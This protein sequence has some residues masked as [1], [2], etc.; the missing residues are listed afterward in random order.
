MDTR[1]EALRTLHLVAS[2]GSF[3]KAA[4]ALKLTKATISKR[5]NE[6][7]SELGVRLLQRSTRRLSL[8]EAGQMLI[9]R[10]ESSLREIDEAFSELEGVNREPQGY[11]KVSA[12]I[13][14]GNYVMQ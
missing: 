3:T 12:P 13:E 8:T 9:A 1:L 5:V 2:L 4:N 10:T 6:L 14:L 11:L 7:E